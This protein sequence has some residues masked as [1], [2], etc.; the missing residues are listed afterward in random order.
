MKN[1][2]KK[3]KILGGGGGGGGDLKLR[4]GNSPPK[5]L[6]KNTGI[7]YVEWSHSRMQFRFKYRCIRVK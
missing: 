6:K 4:G 7:K 5:A 2:Q 3:N 1:L